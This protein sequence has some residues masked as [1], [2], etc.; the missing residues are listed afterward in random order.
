MFDPETCLIALYVEVDT[1]C[2]AQVP[3]P[4]PRQ[5]RKPS[6]S[7]SEI[8]TLAIFG[9]W[10]E[11]RSERGFARWLGR[12]GRALFPTLPH[13]T[14]LNHLQRQH[15]ATITAFALHLGQ[16]L[17]AP[18]ERYEILDGTGLAV[19]NDRR[20][21]TGW[22][23]EVVSIGSCRR[24][25]WFEGFRLLVCTGER[26]V[27]TGW[28]CGSATTGE[29]ALAETLF[30]ARV[31]PQPALPSAG[32]T[33]GSC[34]LA[35]MGLSGEACQQ[36]WAE[37]QGAYVVSPPQTRS[38]REWP[39]TWTWNLARVR[40]VI[41]SVFRRLLHD[42][43]LEHERPHT[44]GGILTRLAA[45]MALHNACIWFNRQHGQPDLAIAD[46]VEW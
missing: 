46:F 31:L 17:I 38:H 26:G 34:Y 9:Q 4:A 2:K 3:A 18:Q 21:G 45:K 44:L 19:R 42:F 22:L 7:V 15:L 41:E 23:P 20:G 30:E 36:R 1:F 8:V 29:R 13:R 6:L 35:D 37:Q 43:R 10:A 27:V 24:L 28:G 40:Q 16:R 11:F 12:H 39:E 25:G 5:G 14:R 32:Q 33:M